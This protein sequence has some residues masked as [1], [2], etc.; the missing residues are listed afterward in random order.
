MLSPAD[1]APS[2][3]LIDTDAVAADL[4]RLA[5]EFAGRERELRT[6]VA[7]RLKAALAKGRAGA[8]QTA[9]EGPPRPHLRRA[10]LP[11]AG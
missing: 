6:A 11:H 7:H 9:A 5:Q 2:T 1:R 4:A 8:E 10:A 3:A